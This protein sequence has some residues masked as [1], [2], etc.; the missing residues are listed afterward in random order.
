MPISVSHSD[1]SGRPELSAPSANCH[2]H[3]ITKIL[4]R[5]NCRSSDEARDRQRRG[6]IV[7]VLRRADLEEN[8]L[9]DERDSV[10]DSECVFLVMSHEQRRHTDAME[11]RAQ[12]VSSR[13]S[14][15]WVEIRQ[16]L[17]HQQNLR[18]DNE[19]AGERD[20]LLLTA[21]QGLNR[22]RSAF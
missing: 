22:S 11:H 4:S 10:C 8:A 15:C 5:Q 6:V 2:C 1:R 9:L 13:L 12:L 18:L 3:D 16:R 21:G 17:V 19:R 20:T 14:Q 7:Q